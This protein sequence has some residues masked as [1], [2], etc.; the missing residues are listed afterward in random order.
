MN[1]FL[2]IIISI[3]ILFTVYA[4]AVVSSPTGGPKDE[5]PPRFG[6][7]DPYNGQ[8]NVDTTKLKVTLYFDEYI[9]EEKL[10]QNLII[11][12]YK[13]TFRYKSKFARNKVIINILDTLEQNTTYFFDFG[14]SV[15]DVTEKN[16]AKNVRF[17]FST[18]DYLDS[19]EVTGQV[20]DLLT[21]E[22][23]EGAIIALYDPYDSLDVNTDPPVY[24]SRTVKDGLFI[25][26][27]FKPGYYN[28]YSVEDANDDYK[29]TL[30]EE[31]VGFF[32]DSLLLDQNIDGV[33]LFVR[34]YDLVDLAFKNV[35]AE[36]TD[37]LVK[38]NKFVV[39]YGI[40]FPTKNTYTD[41]IFSMAEKGEIKLIYTGERDMEDSLQ[42][43]GYAID[44]IEQKIEF[45][46]LIMF[47]SKSEVLAEEEKQTK[48]KG[49]GLLG[50]AIN[51]IGS[52][53]GAEEEEEEIVRIKFDKILPKD[54][55]LIP[56]ETYDVTLKF[57]LPMKEMNIDS[58]YYVYS[59]DTT[60][61][62]SIL[63]DRE[64]TFNFN[65]TEL[66]IPGFEVDS[67]FSLIFNENA[68]VSVKEDSTN[69]KTVSFTIKQLDK[70]GIVEGEVKGSHDSFI[71]QLIDSKAEV[72]QEVKNER[73]F[74]F[75]YVKPGTY[76]LRVLIDENGDG[77]WFPGDFKTRI[78]PEPTAF[79]PKKIKVEAN[80]EIRREE[81]II[82]T[83]KK[84]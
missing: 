72:V 28:V 54:N 37:L 8:T 5:I 61:L 34:D 17:S 40:D 41:S 53:L 71:V 68:F 31:K 74:S 57:P 51:T 73:L 66:T 44:S 83:D 27:R 23:I 55:D 29:F 4:C 11:T 10:K 48:K 7:S 3:Y 2:R 9:Q 46:T 49:G 13:K 59:E 50:G 75:H 56:E 45:D 76:Q 58:M 6:A 12:P 35:K 69:A 21:N 80:W 30:R 19:L 63:I 78:P 16:P 24:F 43:T 33:Q 32:S 52:A 25:L 39:E 82:N 65:K 81:T 79:F 70:Y 64:M 38:F 36:S 1:L 77:E 18:G 20:R 14:K 26:E 47:P 22:P 62:D 15:V 67:A 84:R 42:I 60:R